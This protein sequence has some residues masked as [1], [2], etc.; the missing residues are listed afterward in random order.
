[1]IMTT[2]GKTDDMESERRQK[3]RELYYTWSKGANGRNYNTNTRSDQEVDIMHLFALRE[4]CFAIVL[5][6]SLSFAIAYY[7]FDAPQKTSPKGCSTYHTSSYSRHKSVTIS[8][9]KEIVNVV[10][11]P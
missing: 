6:L 7:L 3:I 8:K 9:P 1:M 10:L 5:L 4:C 11:K 2:L